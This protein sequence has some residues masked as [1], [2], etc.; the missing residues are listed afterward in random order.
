MV[1]LLLTFKTFS[2]PA[3]LVSDTSTIEGLYQYIFENLDKTQVPTGYLEEFGVPLISLEP[4]NGNLTDS[5]VVDM[6]IFRTLNWQMNTSYVGSST[7][8]YPTPSAA[9]TRINGLIADGLPTPIPVLF[10][11]YND[12]KT[13]AF[14]NNYDDLCGAA[15]TDGVTIYSNCPGFYFQLFPNPAGNY[16]I[17]NATAGINESKNLIYGIRITDRSGKLR[18]NTEYKPG[19]STARISLNELNSGIYLVSVFDGVNWSS[20]QLV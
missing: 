19:V 12:V 2:Q 18:K 13:S 15:K 16:V 3:P 6:N 1:C 17:I 20:K 10:E 4:F 7:N 8:D 5:N 14:S 11:T 9:N